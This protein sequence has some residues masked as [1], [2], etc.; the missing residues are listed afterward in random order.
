MLSQLHLRVLAK[1]TFLIIVPYPALRIVYILFISWKEIHCSFPKREKMIA[2]QARL[3]ENDDLPLWRAPAIKKK[4]PFFNVRALI[5]REIMRSK[6][7]QCN[8]KEWTQRLPSHIDIFRR[9][10]FMLFVLLCNWS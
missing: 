1:F 8:T 10:S 4:P 9:S 5:K 3:Q 6:D 2:H 7:A